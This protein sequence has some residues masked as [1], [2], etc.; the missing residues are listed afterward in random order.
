MPL[1][2]YLP[3][4][5]S[6]QKTEKKRFLPTAWDALVHPI[7][8]LPA[9]FPWRGKSMVKLYF[10]AGLF[11]LIGSIVPLVLAFLIG[12][13]AIKLYPEF[14]VEVLLDKDGNPSAKFMLIGTIASFVGGF[15]AELF[16]FRRQLH[17]LGFTLNDVLHFDLSS[18][19]GKWSEAL[20]RSVVALVVG[21][22]A[23]CVVTNLPH[24][25]APHQATADLAA[26]LHG[27]SLLVFAGLAAI[28]A[29]F[30]EEIIFR[31]F[32]FSSLRQLFRE[33]LTAKLLGGSGRLADYLAVSVSAAI[34]AGAHMDPTA[35]WPLFILG[36]VLA[37]LYR[38][39]GTLV[40]P[41]LL[42]AFNN[43]VATLLIVV[44]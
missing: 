5:A 36:I 15:G 4:R 14:A 32:L 18:L 30:F 24:M 28:L 16:Y 21:L 17:K 22:L 2:P 1:A 23:Q 42:H 41:M 13:V 35:F 20:R 26:G 33:G 3:P 40:C 9:D 43:L 10:F 39:S 8:R 38:R 44:R 27:G 25:P 19:N 12:L 37:E 11:Y 29:P 6:V 31:G 34:F 7:V